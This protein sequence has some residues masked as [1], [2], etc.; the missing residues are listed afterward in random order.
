MAPAHPFIR[1]CVRAAYVGHARRQCTPMR[2]IVLIFEK[3]TFFAAPCTP[4]SGPR[5]FLRDSPHRRIHCAGNAAGMLH[6]CVSVWVPRGRAHMARFTCRGFLT[7]E[8][9]KRAGRTAPLT[10]CGNSASTAHVTSARDLVSATGSRAPTKSSGPA[11]CAAISC[12]TSYA[13]RLTLLIPAYVH[14][15]P[16]TPDCLLTPVVDA[17][18]AQQLARNTSHS[19]TAHSSLAPRRRGNADAY[20]RSACWPLAHGLVVSALARPPGC[21]KPS[22]AGTIANLRFR[23]LGVRP[24]SV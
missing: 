3:P 10:P 11:L 22:G 18:A 4:C 21:A 17:G 5:V 23:I 12:A 1:C 9:P 2:S 14:Y 20:R 6:T 7:P 19:S 13:T 24:D 16:R 8:F 15:I